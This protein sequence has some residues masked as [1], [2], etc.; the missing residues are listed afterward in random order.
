V[1]RRPL[2]SGRLWRNRRIQRA[3]LA[4]NPLTKGVVSSDQALRGYKA[5]M[6]A[7]LG[8]GSQTQ[9]HRCPPAGVWP[10]PLSQPFPRSP[11]AVLGPPVRVIARPLP[12]SSG[13]RKEPSTET[14]HLEFA[15][16]ATVVVVN[17]PDPSG[18]RGW[19]LCA[20]GSRTVGL[21]RVGWRICAHAIDALLLVHA[22]LLLPADT[23]K[24]ESISAEQRRR[25][26]D[27]IRAGENLSVRRPVFA[28]VALDVLV[29]S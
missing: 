3:D 5:A 10:V 4:E 11:A 1:G 21:L 18:R 2:R 25:Q 20:S 27:R 17:V 6:D 24:G 16:L 23:P 13:E 26:W 14:R 12:L 9:G 15:R 19:L 8:R 7:A 29:A 22:L 28:D